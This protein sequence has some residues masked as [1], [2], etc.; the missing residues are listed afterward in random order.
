[1]A[2]GENL[3]RRIQQPGPASE[4]RV[5]A[6]ESHGQRFNMQLQPGLTLLEAV[7]RSFAAAGFSSGVARVDGAAL[8]PFVYV[9]PALSKTPEHAAFYSEMFRPAGVARIET[10]VMTFGLRDGAPFFHC[11]A[12]WTEADGKHS[13]GHILPDETVLAEAITVQA[14]GLDSAAFI[15][16][17]DPETNFKLFG[18]VS[19]QSMSATRDGRFFAVRVRPNVDFSTALEEFCV[20]QGVARA[21]I[22]GGVGSTIGA[23]FADGRSVENFATEVAITSGHVAV[24]DGQAT[25]DIGVALVDYTGA[26]AS[27]R[28]KRGDNPVLMTFELVLEVES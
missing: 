4:E 6:V 19:A 3:V 28:L 13:G 25:S 8:A 9:M 27:G 1:M 17:P 2:P 5:V 22:R 23:R 7:R 12:L 24:R 20:A 16:A 10:G 26:T 18:P 15:A 11:H 21:T 14:V